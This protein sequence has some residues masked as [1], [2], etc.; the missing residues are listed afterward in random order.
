VI[1]KELFNRVQRDGAQFLEDAKAESFCD[2]RV[3]AVE[4]TAY[5]PVHSIHSA[6][7][8]GNTC[9]RASANLAYGYPSARSNRFESSRSE[10][11]IAC[12]YVEMYGASQEIL[13]LADFHLEYHKTNAPPNVVFV[14]RGSTV[15]DLH[16]AYCTVNEV[17]AV[18]PFEF[19]PIV[20]VPAPVV[21]ATPATL[22]AF[23]IVATLAEEELK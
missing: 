22:G 5:V 21:E 7:L 23:A 4:K 20:V 15:E 6:P 14:G 9:R 11:T 18:T 3:C 1:K 10:N 2:R 13:R 12:D 19:A 8:S 17:E 16:P